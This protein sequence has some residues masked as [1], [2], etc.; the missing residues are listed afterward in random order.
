MTDQPA[1]PTA[2]DGD[3]DPFARPDGV[4][5]S[6][7]SQGRPE[8][9][10][11]SP[12]PPT[13]SPEDRAAF[14]RPD[15]ARS[16]APAPGERIAPAPLYKPAVP[17][18][19]AD[20]Y[21]PTPGARDGFDAAP[22]TRI[23]PAKNAESPWWKADAQRDPWRDPGAPF[24]LGR[25]AVMAS[26]QLAQLDPFADT[27]HTE[28][29]EDADVE[30]DE[31]VE[32]EPKRRRLRGA[33]LGPSTLTLIV[34]LTLLAGAIG[35]G[36]GYLLSERARNA[37]H[38]ADAKLSTTGTPANRPPGSVADIAQRVAPS[39][40]SIDIRTSSEAGTG[41]GVVIDKAGYIL[42]NNHVVSPV[43]DGKG[44]VRVTFSDNTTETAQ[45]AGRD[46]A[47]DLAVLKVT[48]DGLTVAALG[49]SSKLAV[50]DPVIAIGSPLGLRET[51]TTGI[52]SALNRPVHLSGEGSDT[53]ATINA[54]Q[55]DASINPGNSGGALVDASGA[56]VGIT[57]ALA[58][59]PSATGGQNGSIG[60]GFA[61][62]MSQ[63]RDVAQDLIRTGSVKH[64][65]IGAAT[66][67][68]TD[69]PQ[70]GAYIVQISPGGPADKAGLKQGDVITLVDS[71]LIDSGDALQAA[72]SLHKPGDVVSVRYFRG[73]SETTVKVTLGSD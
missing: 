46:P 20:A 28:D 19:L 38:N 43:A 42:T 64:A 48:H 1:G 11:Y 55:T 10:P 9:A 57:S 31:A 17:A 41:S 30:Q 67:S 73:S 56:V 37:L 35:G 21:E 72:V 32:D 25:P 49:D 3:S 68:V 59:L 13:V 69:G 44:T 65:A 23:S 62:P 47:T 8:P 26:G 29:A 15:G 52:V 70:D 54:I 18:V 39:V 14:G 50:G 24:W 12:P 34:L 6:F 53:D 45:I 66:R 63:A 61:I 36:G 51:V 5:G 33:R 27:E 2:A 16:F 22:G 40:V 4:G 58:A 7:D 60:L 71:T